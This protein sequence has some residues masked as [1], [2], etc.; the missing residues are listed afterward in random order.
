MTDFFH[1]GVSAY[2]VLQG[3]L[4]KMKGQFVDKIRKGG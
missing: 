3:K 2:V 1:E 4:E